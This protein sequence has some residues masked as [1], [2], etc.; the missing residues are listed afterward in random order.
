MPIPRISAKF[1]TTLSLK[2]NVGDTTAALTS[3]QDADGV[4]LPNGTYGITIDEGNSSFEYVEV[5]LVGTA[6]SN[7][8]SF[9]A[10]SL[11]ETVGF[12]KEHRAGAEVK[13]TDFTILG[14]LS[15]IFRG[16]E[17]MDA[18]APLTYNSAPTLSNP[19]S[20]ATVA[21]VISLVTGGAVTFDSQVF[22][23]IAGES[24]TLGDWVYLKESDG[25]WYKTDANFKA[26][27][28]GVKLG[29][30]LGSSTVGNSIPGGVF[31]GGIEKSGTYVAG[32]K[33]YLSNTAGALSTLAGEEEVLVGIGD[34]NTDLIF[35]NLYD[36]ESVSQDQKD[37]LVGTLGTPSEDNKF[38]TENNTTSYGFDQTQLTD[39]GFIEVGESNATTKK[40]K[41]GQ[42]FIPKETKLRGVIIKKEIDTGEYLADLTVSIQ[43]DNGSGSPD[44]TDLTSKN[45]DNDF[46]YAANDSEV[47]VV[48]PTE[49]TLDTANSYWIVLSSSTSSD[50]VHPNVSINTAGGYTNGSLKYFNSTDGWVSLTGQDIYFK[51]ITG[52]KNQLVETDND[53]N[54]SKSFFSR[55]KMPAPLLRQ[56]ISDYTTS[57]AGQTIMAA[58]KDGSILY[59]LIKTSNTA[60]LIQRYEREDTGY[61]IKTHEVSITNTDGNAGIGNSDR[62]GLVVLGD[63][64]YQTYSITTGSAIAMKRFL[65]SNLT[66]ETLMTVP[67]MVGTVHK[68][69]MDGNYIYLQIGTSTTVSKYTVSGTTLTLV[70]TGTAHADFANA[71]TGGSVAFNGKEMYLIRG[72]APSTVQIMKLGNPYGTTVTTTNK[73]TL[74]FPPLSDN[75]TT[76]G[77]LYTGFFGDEDHLY[78]IYA[79]EYN[80]NGTVRLYGLTL[81]PIRKP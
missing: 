4:V 60:G 53:G 39:N 10:T 57:R 15:R 2:V 21:Y 35:L 3:I 29:K 37:A 74:D 68:L 31:V 76:A 59:R 24:I 41:I 71:I 73:S 65:K 54:I 14:R 43:A 19:N 20:L 33:Y 44:G 64:L 46:V 45:L 26:S 52:V 17:T 50:T 79:E 56:V 7:V 13:I 6:L 55:S 58:E 40:N 32:T 49:L 38:V 47:E 16:E 9:S 25:R 66:G 77:S 67:L 61:Y 22:S 62:H 28:V 70:T 36:P 69:W 5:T 1:E 23:G 75:G 18:G 63:Y 78:V 80:D 42:S 27:S 8:L 72:L 34:S 81:Y 12:K 48:F 11:S 30:A 51:T